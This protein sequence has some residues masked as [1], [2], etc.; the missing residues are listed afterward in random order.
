MDAISD[1]TYDQFEKAYEYQRKARFGVTTEKKQDLFALSTEYSLAHCVASDLSMSRGIATVFRKKF[2][3][4]DALERQTPHVGKA[5]MLENN[6]R[7]IYYLVTKERS[8]DKP[9]YPTMWNTLQDWKKKTIQMGTRRVAVSRLGCGLDRFDCRRVRNML[10]VIFCGTGVEI[11]VCNYNPKD[12]TSPR[13]VNCF[14]AKNGHCARGVACKFRH[15]TPVWNFGTKYV[16]RRG[17]CNI[18]ADGKF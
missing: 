9:D 14:F 2:G 12:S 15:D 8:V 3:Q 1:L 17:Q 11:L 10:E 16:L 6:G 18:R 4:L 13:P 5:L 7:V